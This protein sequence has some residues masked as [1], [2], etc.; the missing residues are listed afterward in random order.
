M[1][2]WRSPVRIRS[3]PPGNLPLNGRPHATATA[4][5][6]DGD[7]LYWHGSAAS[8]FLKS[9]V[10]TEV[11]VSIHLTDGIV[12]A[13]SGFD[14]SFNYRSATLFGICEEITGQEKV[15]QLDAFIDKLVPG[16]AADLRASTEQELKAT[17][18]LGM[19]ITEAS[20]KIRSGG[21]HDNPEDSHERVWAG[22]LGVETRFT[23]LTPDDE[24]PVLVEAAENLRRLLG[25]V[26]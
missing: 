4:H 5:W 7:R 18:L 8:R 2:R 12:L 9:V 11:S 17:A 1:S 23:D 10:G 21:V 6:R 14:S 19:T 24:T 13:R 16:R 22:V 20:G 15:Q 3:G 25:K 26:I